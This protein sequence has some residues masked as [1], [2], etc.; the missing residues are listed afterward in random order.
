MYKHDQSAFTLIE[1]AIAL[2][3]IG[4]L[5]VGILKG[6]EMID[7]AKVKGLATDF[8]NIPVYIHGYQ[9][10]FRAL[11]GDDARAASHVTGATVTTLPPAELDNSSIDGKWDDY[12]ASDSE[13]FLFWQHV[14]LAGIAPGATNTADA[15]AHPPRNSLGGLIGITNSRAVAGG[16][17]PI[18][19]LTGTHI[20][21]SAN[22]PGKFIRQ[23][24]RML[25]DGVTNSG[26]L[27]AAITDT[28]STGN[29]AVA[30]VADPD[31]STLYTVCL[32]I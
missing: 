32:G 1:I 7:G 23:L 14:R 9:D 26:S 11:P 21:C 17:L 31:D 16:G 27:M 10:K 19:G 13:T 18:A 24:D 12:T 6:K 8:R 2:V 20:I 29:A 4:L 3:A 15:A 5:L 28:A 30:P 25:D 22:I